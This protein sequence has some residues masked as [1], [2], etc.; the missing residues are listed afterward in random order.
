M[1]NDTKAKK[2]AE[3]E[4]KDAENQPT[5]E[6]EIETI[7]M[8]DVEMQPISWL[9]EDRIARGKITVIAGNPGLGKS[10]ITAYITSIVSKGGNWVD[11]VNN[12]PAGNV[13]ILSAEDDPADTIKPRLIAAEADIKKCYVM[14]SVR[15]QDKSGRETSRTFNL[16]DDVK[17][18]EEKIK[19]IGN[20]M[21]VI[22]DPISA[23]LGKTD[24]HN[25]SDMRAILAPLAEM[26][27]KHNT[28][29]ILVTHFNKS[30]QQEAIGRVIGSIGLIAAARAGYAVT[31]DEQQPEVR[32]FIP[33]KNNIGNDTTG[34]AYNIQG[35][36]IEQ[37]IETSKINWRDGT[38]DANQILNPEKKTPTNG[39]KE[40][41]E[42]L[43]SSGA[44][45][46]NDIFEEASGLGY[47]KG[48]IQRAAKKITIYK[49]KA[50]FKDG[51]DRSL[52]PFPEEEKEEVSE[53]AEGNTQKEVTPSTPSQSSGE[54]KKGNKPCYGNSW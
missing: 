35:V 48:A 34:F 9:W 28:A 16:V 1:I 54:K 10:Q 45:P 29:F 12:N 27:M 26:A 13:I 40:F 50:G 21:L 24:S 17:R 23:Y 37:D 32:Y 47:S 38:V 20:V 30:T 41:L 42:E 52:T 51:W 3:E 11:T 15:S 43:L 44:K 33:I 5:W 19:S 8:D 39:A 7:C 18:L 2:M 36:T 46:V 14:L 31:K 49:K 6:D 22:I 53:D 25:N 4:V